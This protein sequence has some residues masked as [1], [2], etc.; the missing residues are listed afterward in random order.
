MSKF[1][2]NSI[3][4]VAFFLIS[5]SGNTIFAKTVKVVVKGSQCDQIEKMHI[6]K[7]DGLG[8]EIEHSTP[9]NA[10]GDFV[11][12]IETDGRLFRYIG[13]EVGKFKSIVLGDEK[14]VVVNGSCRAFNTASVAEGLNFDYNTMMNK[15]RTFS[16]QEGSIGRR[17]VQAMKDEEKKE[18]ITLEFAA[19]DQNKKDLIETY[20]K[21]NKWL[22]E[23]AKLYTCLLYTSPS[24]RDKRQSRMPSSA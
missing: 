9:K 13:I 3:L 1:I 14:Q 7:F 5:L 4:L 8:F 12:Q 11:F 21:K 18:K 6:F 17:F 24:P 2:Y 15:I 22:G 19:L 20:S 23:V 16:Q 10:D